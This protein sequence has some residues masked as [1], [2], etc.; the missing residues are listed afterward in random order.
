[1]SQVSLFFSFVFLL[2]TRGKSTKMTPSYSLGLV[3]WNHQ[4]LWFDGMSRVTWPFSSD[5]V[6]LEGSKGYREKW[7]LPLPPWQM[8]LGL[9]V[10][11]PY[12]ALRVDRRKPSLESTA[13]KSIHGTCVTALGALGL[14]YLIS[15]QRKNHWRESKPAVETQVKASH[16]T[17]QSHR[18]LGEESN[19]TMCIPF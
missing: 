8:S 16:S 7:V 13:R 19:G 17:T 18:P 14:K 1:M 9:S 12:S 2:H 4:P 5:S 11:L 3:V 10:L 6:W 15:D